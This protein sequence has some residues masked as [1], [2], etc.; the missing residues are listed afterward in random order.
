MYTTD[1]V[2]EIFIF[3][4]AKLFWVDYQNLLFGQSAANLSICY[5]LGVNL[6]I[7]SSI[8]VLRHPEF[9]TKK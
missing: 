7:H 4:M 2:H 3:N 6:T 5:N 9:L 8:T 1:T